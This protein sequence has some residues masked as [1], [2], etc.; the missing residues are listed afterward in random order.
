MQLQSLIVIHNFSVD[1]ESECFRAF[2]I[3]YGNLLPSPSL[4][5]EPGPHLL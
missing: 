1:Y 4:K 2:Y 3:K 5:V